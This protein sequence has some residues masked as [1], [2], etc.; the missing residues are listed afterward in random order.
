MENL[1]P[2]IL[3]MFKQNN[4][5]IFDLT[6]EEREQKIKEFED[7]KKKTRAEKVLN[8]N[9]SYY[10]KNKDKIKDVNKEKFKEYYQANKTKIISRVKSKYKE[11]KIKNENNIN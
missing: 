10:D 4:I 1:R 2:I 11:N 3:K 9:K 7:E 5:N 8:Y 6:K